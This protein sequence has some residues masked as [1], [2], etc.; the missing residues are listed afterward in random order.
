MS[1]LPQSG[2]FRA[3]DTNPYTWLFS[4]V[5][6]CFTLSKKSTS[7]FFHSALSRSFHLCLI[8][9]CIMSGHLFL[10]IHNISPSINPQNSFTPGRKL[11]R[12]T[13]SPYPAVVRFLQTSNRTSSWSVQV[14]YC[15]Q[16]FV[17]ITLSGSIAVWVK[18][19]SGDGPFLCL[20]VSSSLTPFAHVKYNKIALK[21]LA[22][23][24]KSCK[25]LQRLRVK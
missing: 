14:S 15:L 4:K 23:D 3:F 20:S 13:K 8:S 9:S 10:S 17:V 6:I 21:K 12:F 25:N 19:Q 1:Q 11:A 5:S 7:W 16:L 24:C 18:Q 22:K 2:F